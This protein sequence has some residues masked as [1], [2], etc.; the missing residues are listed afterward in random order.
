MPD[1]E[2]GN[3]ATLLKEKVTFL[4]EGKDEISPV[5]IMAI[6]LEVKFTIFFTVR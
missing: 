3:A 6:Q 5:Q 4:T 2:I 1:E